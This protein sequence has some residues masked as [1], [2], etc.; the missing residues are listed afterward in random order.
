LT[1]KIKQAGQLAT[2]VPRT[3]PIPAKRLEGSLVEQGLM[4]VL[5]RR[6]DEERA[7]ASLEL[8]R[9]AY[10]DWNE[11][12]VSQVQEIVQVLRP[13]VKRVTAEHVA[14]LGPVANDIKEL[15]QEIF[16]K[17]HA[18]DLAEL[19]EDAAA[20]GK[21]IAQMPFLGTAQGS[22]LLWASTDGA[23][24]VHPG[25][26]RV[27]ERLGLLSRAGGPKKAREA[28]AQLLPAG[29]E[30]DVLCALSEV[31]DRWCDARRPLC[32][33][34]PLVEEC[35]HGKKVRKDWQVQQAR[36]EVQRKRE[37]A[38][39]AD[40][41]RKEK[42]K[43][44]R[45]EARE[46]KRREQQGKKLERERQKR[47]REEA[48]RKEKEERERQRAEAQKKREAEAEKRRLAAER[49][50]AEADKRKAEA[51]RKKAG[52]AKK[53][54]TRAGSRPTQRKTTARKT[55]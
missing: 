14:E 46:A 11:L 50:K 20:A 33:Q 31:A 12:R 24:P 29:N 10:A 21:L 42:A 35:P 48:R 26:T 25:V 51:E 2:L 17:T 23:L 49:K 45:E 13:R 34:C 15:L 43:R 22:Y 47:L 44:E 39:R 32:W 27:L 1:K 8:L 16:Q 7:V 30:L 19:R 4:L 40:Q 38:R 41:E 52:K 5:L 18:L 28:V 54:A 37:E 9:K 55:R 53:P 6:M 36:Q 3:R